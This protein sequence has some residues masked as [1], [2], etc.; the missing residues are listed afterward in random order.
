M[1]QQRSKKHTKYVTERLSTIISKEID[2][3]YYAAFIK[4][5]DS[6]PLISMKTINLKTVELLWFIDSDDIDCLLTQQKR[7][8]A[9]NSLNFLDISYIWLWSWLVSTY[10]ITGP[11]LAVTYLWATI[12]ISSTDFPISVQERFTIFLDVSTLLWVF[13]CHFQQKIEQHVNLV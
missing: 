11:I 7:Q 3:I 6:S 9:N 12:S 4:T 10:L 5:E 2:D 8:F 13:F 1:W